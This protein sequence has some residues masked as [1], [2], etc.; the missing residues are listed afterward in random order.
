MGESTNL[1]LDIQMCR[2]KTQTINTI[3]LKTGCNDFISILNVGYIIIKVTQYQWLTYSLK[4]H[5]NCILKLMKVG[6][7]MF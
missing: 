4:I 7:L 1:R 3:L 6:L 5:L 2:F